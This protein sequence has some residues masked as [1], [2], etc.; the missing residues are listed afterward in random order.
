MRDGIL[1]SRAA[2]WIITGLVVI[3]SA[4]YGVSKTMSAMGREAEA[5]YIGENSITMDLDRKIAVAYNISTIASKYL[6]KDE[7][8]P[9]NQ[10][11]DNLAN[12]LIPTSKYTA[13]MALDLEAKTL[14]EKVLSRDA[15]VKDTDLSY[16]KQLLAEIDGIN[17][18]IARNQYNQKASEYNA[19]LK[20]M[21]VAVFS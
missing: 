4:G 1:K 3:L 17:D 9:L 18:I 21:P 12:A 19:E 10:A 14:A 6:S 11:I 16:I 13:S 2:A 8:A 5:L 20:K 15:A 7:I